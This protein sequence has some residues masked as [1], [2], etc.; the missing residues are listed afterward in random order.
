MRKNLTDAVVEG[1]IRI[2]VLR[3]LV[4]VDDH[5]IFEELT[6]LEAG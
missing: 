1:Q 6:R 4:T 3:G 5:K 2:T